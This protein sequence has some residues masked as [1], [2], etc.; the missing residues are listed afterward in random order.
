MPCLQTSSAQ[1]AMW[2]YFLF[3]HQ[4]PLTVFLYHPSL[5]SFFVTMQ[6]AHIHVWVRHHAKLHCDVLFVR[7]C[8]TSSENLGLDN[9]MLLVF[10]LNGQNFHLQMEPTTRLYCRCLQLCIYQLVFSSSTA[11]ILP[12][13][14]VPVFFFVCTTHLKR[15]VLNC[16]PLSLTL[17]CPLFVVHT[18]CEPGHLHVLKEVNAKN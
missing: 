10:A 13:V 7:D 1:D 2:S 18:S 12:A 11:L 3:S 5:Y 9:R 4:P 14:L 16:L 15:V 8:C 17:C 6:F